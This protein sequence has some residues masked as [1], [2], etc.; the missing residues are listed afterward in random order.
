MYGDVYILSI[1]L[2]VVCGFDQLTDLDKVHFSK[3]LFIDAF[4]TFRLDNLKDCI[5]ACKTRSKCS[6]INYK[7]SCG[8]CHLLEATGRNESDIRV[9]VEYVYGNKSEWTMVRKLK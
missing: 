4:V 2:F 1:S 7:R 9:A 8:L 3:Q 6:A 5:D